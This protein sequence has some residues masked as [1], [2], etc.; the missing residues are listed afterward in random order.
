MPIA[1]ILIGALLII[2]AFQNTMGQLASQL[3]G[4]VPGFFVW[5]MA[6]AAILA[7][8]YVP[9]MR[10]PSRWLLGLVALVIVLTNYKKILGGFQ[11]FTGS[12]G[13]TV[14]STAADPATAFPSSPAGPLPSAAAVAGDAASSASS[15]SG[16]VPTG[17]AAGA[18]LNTA[19]SAAGGTLAQG[20]GTILNFANPSTYLGAFTGIGF[21]GLGVGI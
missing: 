19:A 15:T 9:G 8:G 11:A 10:T 21:G 17:G 18:I 3:M 2:V 12:G 14:G 4:D 20:A 7:L 6:I 16:G 5:A 1:L 13:S